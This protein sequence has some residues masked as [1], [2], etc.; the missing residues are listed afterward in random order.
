[1]EKRR[2]S[3]V[4]AHPDRLLREGI[5]RILDQSSFKVVGQA[6]SGPELSR[7]AVELNPDLVLLDWSVS[8][9]TVG[10]LG[11]LVRQKPGMIAVTLAKPGVAENV[12][13]SIKAGI[14][15]HLSVDLSPEELLQSLEMLVR[16]DV[17]ISRDIVHG[18]TSEAGTRPL[19]TTTSG[20]SERQ[21]EVLKLVG[22]GS[23]N[24]EIGQELFISEHTVKAHVRS[25]LSKLDLRNRHQAAAYA[26]QNGL[27]HNE[28]EP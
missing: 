16:G 26:I 17:V 7:L 22:R 2:I 3:V 18:L 14:R 20:L 4:L 19:P 1:M 13:P 10:L 27:A 25:I 21:I 8:E 23:T 9:A 15:G 12:T 11:E 24:R 28:T 6:D 5:A